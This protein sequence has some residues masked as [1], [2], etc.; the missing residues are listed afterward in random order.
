MKNTVLEF[1]KKYNLT[2]KTLIVGF[3]G[4]HDSMCLL[5][6]L[7]KLSKTNNFKLIAAHFNHN[8]RGIESK[9]EQDVCQ[10]FCEERGIIFYTKTAAINMKQSEAVARAMRYDFFE[11]TKNKFNADAFLTA[12]NKN[13]NAETV[14]YR[15]IKGTGITGL[16]GIAEKR[17]YIYRPILNI[18]RDKIDKYCEDNELLPNN[19][20]SNNN[21]KYKRNLIRHKLIPIAED[22]NHHAI[23][24]IVS[25]SQIAN[26]ETCIIEEYMEYVKSA[27]I[28]NGSIVTDR[29]MN[30]SAP[31]KRKLLYDLI[32]SY[33]LDYDAEKVYSMYNFIENNNTSKNGIKM[34]LSTGLWLFVSSKFIELITKTHKLEDEICIRVNGEY[35]IGD[36]I[37]EISPYA[38]E[39]LNSYP[40]DNTYCAYVDLSN[41][42]LDLV[43]RTRRDGDMINPLGMDGSMKLKKYLISK[44]IPQH[45]KDELILLCKNN[46]IL[47][48]AGHG[49]SN[50][51]QVKEKPTHKL[52]LRPKQN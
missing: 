25:L 8:W 11:K 12:H 41:F 34:S 43:L 26:D 6:I 7:H 48:V 30:L 20:S 4:G 29:Y 23:D 33:N 50:K 10:K 13:D 17:D 51:I 16:K 9:M 31:V 37:F 27:I 2:D 40:S 18:T 38:G 19:D 28:V 36:Y 21:T 44:S 46:E 15:V 1:L 35:E 3:S 32:T 45:K 47:W 22:I 14:L 24:S 5:D 52:T 49:L 42:D 39:D